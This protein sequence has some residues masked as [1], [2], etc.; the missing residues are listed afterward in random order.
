MGGPLHYM[1]PQGSQ[2]RGHSSG[3]RWCRPGGHCR[4]V[5]TP[6]HLRRRGLWPQSPSACVSCAQTFFAG[7]PVTSRETLRR[8]PVSFFSFGGRRVDVNLFFRVRRLFSTVFFFL[9]TTVRHRPPA[10]GHIAHVLPK[11]HGRARSRLCRD[12]IDFR[13]ERACDG[14]IKNP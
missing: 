5:L 10:F 2:Q 11:P 1:M 9:T 8:L 13:R 6:P 3:C 12:F 14:E 4:C 7:S